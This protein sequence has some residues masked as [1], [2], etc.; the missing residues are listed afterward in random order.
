MAFERWGRKINNLAPAST[1]PDKSHFSLRTSRP[2]SPN[3]APSEVFPNLPQSNQKE[4]NPG[5][6]KQKVGRK[7]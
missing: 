3:F 7:K 4:D 6:K 2:P 1:K 5:K